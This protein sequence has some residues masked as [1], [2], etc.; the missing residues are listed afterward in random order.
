MS[1]KRADRL[2]T[3]KMGRSVATD[4]LSSLAAYC[5]CFEIYLFLQRMKKAKAIAGRGSPLDA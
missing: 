3:G 2:A 5:D 4:L 1:R